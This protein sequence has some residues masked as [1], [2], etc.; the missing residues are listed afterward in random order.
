M[1]YHPIDDVQTHLLTPSEAGA[2]ISVQQQPQATVHTVTYE[3]GNGK[4]GGGARWVR[5]IRV[6]VDGDKAVEY[7]NALRAEPDTYRDVLRFANWIHG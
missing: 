7:A 6:F 5:V 2:A 1:A 3:A 4:K